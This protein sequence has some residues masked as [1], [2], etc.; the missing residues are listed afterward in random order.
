RRETTTDESGNYAI[1]NLPSGFYRL[2]FELN[3][4]RPVDLQQVEVRP[5]ENNRSDF[6]M[7]VGPLQQGLVIQAE[8]IGLQTDNSSISATIGQAQLQQQL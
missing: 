7:Q 4:F 2:Q 1:T 5:N 8:P 6:Q 3:G